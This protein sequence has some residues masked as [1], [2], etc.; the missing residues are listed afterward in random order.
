MVMTAARD[1][2][3]PTRRCRASPQP[4]GVVTSGGLTSAGRMSFTWRRPLWEKL[5]SGARRGGPCGWAS[6]PRP[7]TG[8][9]ASAAAL[10]TLLAGCA[11]AARPAART[12]AGRQPASPRPTTDPRPR[13]L[14]VT[15][16]QP[17]GDRDPGDGAGVVLVS[18]ARLAADR[19][20][21]RPRLL[22]CPPPSCGR[23]WY[24]HWSA[25]LAAG[26][27]GCRT[28]WL[29]CCGSGRR[30]LPPPVPTRAYPNGNSPRPSSVRPPR[31]RARRAC[32]I[33]T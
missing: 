13:L 5:F 18:A 30:R 20:R 24:W 21:L 4:R 32:V 31:T 10:A 16:D 22:I 19:H 2:G 28:E 6:K 3:V 25:S 8:L 15:K 17:G 26:T 33:A 29:A 11:S 14:A 27:G 9:T 12:S 23:C 1:T 7:S